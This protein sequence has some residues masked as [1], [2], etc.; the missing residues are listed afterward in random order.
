MKKRTAATSERAKKAAI[1]AADEAKE[2]A[3]KKEKK[4]LVVKRGRGRPPK[5]KP[6]VVAVNEKSDEPDIDEDGAQSLVVEWT[7][8]LTWSLVT[9]IEE[10]DEI[11]DG[12]YP[13]PG[14]IKRTGGKPKTHFHD[15]LGV[16]I[17]ADNPAYTEFLAIDP[18]LS[19]AEQT[20][21]KA[22][23]RKLLAG[24]V[25]NK[26]KT[27][28]DTAR[29]H[30][31]DMG[32]TGA[33]LRSAA[34][35]TPG[36]KLATQWDVIKEDF[37]WL[38]NMR[39]LIAARPNL[40][41]VGLGNNDTP[42]DI[43]LLLRTRTDDDTSSLAPDD[44]EDLPAQ[45]VDSDVL[46]IDSDSDDEIAATP[47][48]EGALKRKIKPEGKGNSKKT[49]PKK[50]TKPQTGMSAPAAAVAA[51][52]PTNA[53]DRFSATVLAEEET[54]QRALELRTAKNKAHKDVALAK[55]SAE[56][57]IRL[58][59]EESK[60][61]D[62]AEKAALVRLRME[63]EHQMRMA[64]MQQGGPSSASFSNAGQ[65]GNF[66]MFDELPML[67]GTSSSDGSGFAGSSTYGGFDGF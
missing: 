40:K 17:F 16:K 19:E 5:E 57:E 3:E 52:K 44:T 14:A 22:E 20:K 1:I 49:P 66:S 24:K 39:D 28:T 38:F 10:D 6:V 53:K 26:I 4:L 33:G 56:K 12:L 47:T 2:E 41:P 54:A 27:L 32:Q 11:R 46:T 58:A 67:P 37:P 59:K 7:K 8:D 36:S 9:G 23:Q 65:S 15:A 51:K 42:I 13:G 63:Q 18:E 29:I 35:I 31:L 25:K 64:Q 55:I 61:A 60:R 43:D 50:K 45:L 48:L 21:K 30:I 62:K 34:E